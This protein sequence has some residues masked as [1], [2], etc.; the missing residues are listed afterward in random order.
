MQFFRNVSSFVLKLSLTKFSLNNNLTA[1]KIAKSLSLGLNQ[2]F[3]LSSGAFMALN[4][5]LK[6]DQFI[7]IFDSLFFSSPFH[8]SE[9]SQQIL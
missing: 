9:F 7:P 5:R 3:F 2:F 4:M 8:C 1:D 6:Q